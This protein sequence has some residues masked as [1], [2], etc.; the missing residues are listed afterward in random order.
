MVNKGLIT[1]LIERSSITNGDVVYEIGAGKGIITEGLL[2]RS[3]KVVAFEIDSSL[4]NKLAQRF[5]NEKSLE[6]KLGNFLTHSLSNQPYK[7]FANIPFNITSAI[8]KKL[9]QASNP[10]EDA[11]LIVQKEAAK[12]FVGKPYDNKNSQMAILLKPWF[13]FEVFHQFKVVDF[14]PR[15][16]VDII[17]LRIKKRDKPLVDYKHKRQ[18][19]DLVTYTFNQFK[20]NVSEG[21]S[22]VFGK[23]AVVRLGS[24]LGFPLSS[25]PSELSFEDWIGLFNSFLNDL[26]YK[27]QGIVKGSYTKLVEQQGKL[28]KIHR[29]RVDKNWRR[30]HK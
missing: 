22:E 13:D 21:L 11:Y 30:Y 19:E 25:K 12:K 3:E 24:R 14:F 7:V 16:G 20:P 15:P 4:F 29:T 23:Q 9:T 10:P 8:I 1:E 2:K 5:R 27:H 17:M 18:Y 6:L 26:D 28:E